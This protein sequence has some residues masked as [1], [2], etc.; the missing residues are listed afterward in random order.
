[1]TTGDAIT[2]FGLTARSQPARTL[3]YTTRGIA[4]DIDATHRVLAIWVFPSGEFCTW[5]RRVCAQS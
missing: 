1:M 5:L 2:V 3:V 4:F